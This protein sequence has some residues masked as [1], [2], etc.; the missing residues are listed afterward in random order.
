MIFVLYSTSRHII[1]TIVHQNGYAVYHSP[2][3]FKS[4]QKA[5]QLLSL[6]YPFIFV[7][8]CCD[9]CSSQFGCHN[10]LVFFNYKYLFGCMLC[11]F[12]F[13]F[14]SIFFVSTLCNIFVKQVLFIFFCFVTMFP[15]RFVTNIGNALFFRHNIVAVDCRLW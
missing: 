8:F 11:N 10:L 1:K 7:F 13:G 15:L 4:H 12:S 6:T 2:N 9:I 14:S 5:S 3:E